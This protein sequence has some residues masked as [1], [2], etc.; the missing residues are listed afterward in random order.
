MAQLVASMSGVVLGLVVEVEAAGSNIA[1]GKILTAST[2]IYSVLCIYTRSKKET[3][4][5]YGGSFTNISQTICHSLS[6]DSWVIGPWGC[7]SF[8]FHRTKL[9]EQLRPT[10]LSILTS[11]HYTMTS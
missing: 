1:R 9:I 6:A 7:P 10:V 5:V 8:H 3:P 2:C 11:R 4:H